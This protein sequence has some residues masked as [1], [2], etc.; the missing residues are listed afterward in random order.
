MEGL[1]RLLLPPE[2]LLA[3][4]PEVTLSRESAY[5]ARRGQPAP[6]GGNL[7]PGTRV[8]LFEEALF[9]EVPAGT[10]GPRIFLGIGE[11][12]GDGRVTPRRLLSE[13]R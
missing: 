1:D 5:H 11:I 6:A 7:P 10:A 12:T 2:T 3:G 8:V 4:W 9:E 13:T